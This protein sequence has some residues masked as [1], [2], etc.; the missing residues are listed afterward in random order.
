[1]VARE[2]QSERYRIEHLINISGRAIN[3]IVGA[4]GIDVGLAM[5]ER[6][7][8]CSTQ[9]AL[10]VL[11]GEP[12]RLYA[13]P[14]AQ[15][16]WDIPDENRQDQWLSVPARP[17]HHHELPCP[18]YIENDIP[19]GVNT[20]PPAVRDP[21]PAMTIVGAVAR[22][23]LEI[24]PGKWLDQ[25]A[26]EPPERPYDYLAGTVFAPLGLTPQSPDN[27]MAL[28]VE[29]CLSVM[30]FWSAFIAKSEF[31]LGAI[32]APASTGNGWMADLVVWTNNPLAITSPSG[33]SI[34]SLATI[35]AGQDDE[36]RLAMVN[37]FIEKFRPSMTL[38]GGVPVYEL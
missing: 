34:E 32:A 16:L 4:G 30:T 21:R 25:N 8:V 17:R 28:S 3:E 9:P 7:I 36:Q 37:T 19:F 20:D 31:E 10:L 22:T 15:E 29:Q 1:M 18:M 24:D 35:P 14:Y 6:N 12:M 23:P 11:D 27:P 5:A 38:V 13:F 33:L 26:Q 2:F